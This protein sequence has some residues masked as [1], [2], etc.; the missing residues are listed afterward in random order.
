MKTGQI[1]LYKIRKDFFKIADVCVCHGFYYDRV[2][3]RH[4]G[5]PTV[6]ECRFQL[7]LIV[8]C[9]QVHLQTI[10]FVLPPGSKP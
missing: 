3:K 1:L 8:S 7:S 5:T 10:V 4:P 6:I 9:P 2:E